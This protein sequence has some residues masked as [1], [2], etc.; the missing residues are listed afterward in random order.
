MNR[1]TSLIAGAL[2]AL[3]VASSMLFIVDQRQFAVIYA[4]GEIKEVITEPGLKIKLPPPLQNV[5]MLDRR[6]QTLDSP[7][8]AP[9]SRPRRRA[10][11]S[12][13]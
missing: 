12:T 9:S 1:F 4:L 11:S 8:P 5:V 2:V 7:S 3:L 10:S 6:V 13:G